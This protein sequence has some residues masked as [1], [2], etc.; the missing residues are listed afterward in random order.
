MC[1]LKNVDAYFDGLVVVWPLALALHVVDDV[2]QL[3]HGQI[4]AI[5]GPLAC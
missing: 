2:L 4:L 3:L 1:S 5:N